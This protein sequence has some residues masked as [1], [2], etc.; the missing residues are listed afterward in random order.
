MMVLRA[1]L[2]AC[3]IC[4]V[5]P[6]SRGADMDNLIED[7]QRYARHRAAQAAECRV[8]SRG[9]IPPGYQGRRD[10]MPTS[11]AVLDCPAALMA[12]D[13]GVEVQRWRAATLTVGNS[14]QPGIAARVAPY[15]EQIGSMPPVDA[16][17]RSLPMLPAVLS[18]VSDLRS[19]AASIQRER[20]T[21]AGHSLV[22]VLRR[23][24]GR[25]VFESRAALPLLQ[26]LSALQTDEARAEVER[27]VELRSHQPS[28]TAE[29]SL[30]DMIALLASVE[31]VHANE[32]IALRNRVLAN[33]RYDDLA[34][35]STAFRRLPVVGSN[36]P[37]VPY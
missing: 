5:L 4:F 23:L 2:F 26:A 34:P 16:S 15:I 1:C 31:P 24:E 22:T 20:Y 9:G 13:R 30:A 10:L 11:H 14:E 35:A 19:I 32:I 29:P 33:V 27:W 37:G 36:A 6:S 28:T 7:V 25:T 12:A 18:R 17:A 8:V 3:V 21:P